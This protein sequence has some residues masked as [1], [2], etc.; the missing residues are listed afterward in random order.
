MLKPVRTVAPASMPVTREEAKAACR[1]DFDDDDTLIDGLIAAAVDHLDGWRGV[2][3]G[4]A[5]VTQTWQQDFACLDDPLRLAIWPVA[6]VTS[7]TYYD[8]DNASQ[9]L[10]SS[11]YQTFADARGNYLGL[12]P[13]QDWPSLYS[14]RDAVRVTYV[15]GTEVNNVPPAAKTAILMLVA[16]WYANREAA[17]DGAKVS[18]PHGFDMLVEP[19]RRRRV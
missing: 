1:V 2:L 19:L 3:G 16:H 6:S 4:R 9:T 15:A 18:V 12:R 11:V 10:A 13:A 14:R 7:L 5:L 17:S 8:A